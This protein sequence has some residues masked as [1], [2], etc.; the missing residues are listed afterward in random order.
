MVEGSVCL[1]PIWLAG[2]SVR[3]RASFDVIF[4]VV[5]QKQIAMVGSGRQAIILA[6]ISHD[7][8]T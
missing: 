8:S 7:D 5:R 4:C 1:T 3:I 6:P 2:F